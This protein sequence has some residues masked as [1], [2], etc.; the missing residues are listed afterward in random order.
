MQMPNLNKARLNLAMVLDRS[1]LN[2]GEQFK[3][4]VAAG[5]L[6]QAA[7][8]DLK[9]AHEHSTELMDKQLNFNKS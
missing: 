8:K 3:I 6:A 5:E 9:A 4:F 1:G 2:P 7:V